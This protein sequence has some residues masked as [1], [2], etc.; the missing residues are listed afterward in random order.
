MY[1]TLSALDFKSTSM[2]K[3][4]VSL[5]GNL[6][7]QN[8][9][10]LWAHS[11]WLHSTWVHCSTRVYSS[12]LNLSPCSNLTSPTETLTPLLWRYLGIINAKQTP[13]CHYCY[14]LRVSLIQ[15]DELSA[16]DILRCARQH[17]AL[18]TT[19]MELHFWPSYSLQFTCKKRAKLSCLLSKQ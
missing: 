1:S 3:T 2:Y 4:V 7:I 15:K 6:E 18:L 17:A 8:R 10:R 12:V 5:G 16:L 19:I 11:N 9:N 13:R 14:S